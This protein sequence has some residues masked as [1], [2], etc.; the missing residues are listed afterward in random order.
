MEIEDLVKIMD[1]NGRI[2]LPELDIMLLKIQNTPELISTICRRRDREGI[3]ESAEE[4]EDEVA[5]EAAED[6]EEDAEEA[7]KPLRNRRNC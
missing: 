1:I 6:G 5:E 2:N 7:K 3:E 4:S